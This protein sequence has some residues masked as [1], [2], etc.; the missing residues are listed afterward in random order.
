[1]R[2]AVTR[3]V[4]KLC[5]LAACFGNC[6]T[7]CSA[8][9]DPSPPQLEL[10]L[11]T[12]ESAHVP[13]RCKRPRTPSRMALTSGKLRC[14]GPPAL[15]L[16]HV[17]ERARAVVLRALSEARTA[18]DRQ[19][20]LPPQPEGLPPASPA[21]VLAPTPLTLRCLTRIASLVIAPRQSTNTS[22]RLR[23]R[24]YRPH[25]AQCNSS[26][27]GKRTQYLH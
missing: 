24:F 23:E 2:A 19:R 12:K 13:R 6:R 9:R 16:G 4:C 22:H 15:E 26:S 20:P 3:F 8:A 7:P 14:L 1:M 21:N 18:E 27:A 10:Q 11:A 5:A 25:T 17:K